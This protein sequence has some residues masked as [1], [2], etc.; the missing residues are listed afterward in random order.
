MSTRDLSHDY[1]FVIVGGG[2]SGLTVANRLS[3]NIGFR[4][5]VL[6]AGNNHLDDPRVQIPG[7]CVQAQGSDLD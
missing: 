7:L 4:I 5:L 3:E 6:E 1:D 2:T